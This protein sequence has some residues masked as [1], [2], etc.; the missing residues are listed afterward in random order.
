MA[1]ND[2]ATQRASQSF[3]RLTLRLLEVDSS[4]KVINSRTYITNTGTHDTGPIAIRA[5]TRVPVRT[6]DKGDVQY[7]DSGVNVDFRNPLE[8]NGKMDIQVD[9]QLSSVPTGSPTDGSAPLL[10]Q[11]TWRSEVKVPLDKPTVIF[12]SDNLSDKGT[13]RIELTATRVE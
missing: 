11:N 9:L 13:M 2:Q 3:Y 12:S 4:G 6:S 10:R 1:Q 8:V 7:I 5:G